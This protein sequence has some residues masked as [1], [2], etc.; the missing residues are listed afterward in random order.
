[1]CEPEFLLGGG[2][3]PGTGS[4]LMGSIIGAF[5][6]P[7]SLLL[8]LSPSL[9]LSFCPSNLVHPLSLSSVNLQGIKTARPRASGSSS[10][11]QFS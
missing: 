7:F 2:E 8:S 1:M 4:F 5:S 3:C 6:L 9:S 10:L 11:A